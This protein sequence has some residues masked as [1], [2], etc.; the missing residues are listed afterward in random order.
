MID[1]ENRKLKFSASASN[2]FSVFSPSNSLVGRKQML[3]KVKYGM[4]LFSKYKEAWLTISQTVSFCLL[5]ILKQSGVKQS[6]IC[7]YKTSRED[8]E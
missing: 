7:Y 5:K 8:S 3:S 1:I 2:I 6:S 4:D